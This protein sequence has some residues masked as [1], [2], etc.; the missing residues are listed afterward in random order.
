MVNHQKEDHHSL[1]AGMEHLSIQMISEE[2]YSFGRG[3]QNTS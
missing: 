2:E 1:A 3:L